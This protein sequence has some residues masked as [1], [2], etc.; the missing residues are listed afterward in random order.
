[1]FEA[2]AVLTVVLIDSEFLA[3][4]RDL[5]EDE[6]VFTQSVAEDLAQDM[7]GSLVRVWLDETKSQYMAEIKV[8]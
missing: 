1:M 7:K 2:S 4:L 6:A 3:E 5:G 8:V